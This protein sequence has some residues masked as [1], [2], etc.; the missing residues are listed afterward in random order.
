M[1]TKIKA[2]AITIDW[3]VLGMANKTKDNAKKSIA[4][5]CQPHA[6]I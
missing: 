4:N 1:N 6:P 5:I 3:F 2:I